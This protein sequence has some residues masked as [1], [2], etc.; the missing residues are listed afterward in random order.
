M[1]SLLEGEPSVYVPDGA[2][3]TGGRGDAFV[4]IDWAEHERRKR[5]G[6][7]AI[8]QLW[9][10]DLLMNLPLDEPV[11]TAS[12]TRDEQWCLDR[13]P[14]GAIEHD[15]RWAVRRCKPVCTITAIVLW[16][17]ELKPLLKRAAPFGRVA[18]RLL[19]LDRVP[20]DFDQIAWQARYYGTGV[21]A[22]SGSDVLELVAA[23]PVR[24]RYYKP[25]RWKVNE[26]AYRAWLMALK[27]PA[28]ASQD[29]PA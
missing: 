6:L 22:A 16:G 11:D 26:Y 25:A 10:L 24:P 29:C 5:T 19:V 9:Y 20:Q 21:W 3:I 15:G 8:T 23:E 4:Q 14:A 1:G 28:P 7:T 2:R 18:P 12:L 17:S 27:T 13:V